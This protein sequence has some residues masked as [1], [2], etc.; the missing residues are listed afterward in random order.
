MTK[1]SSNTS[2][3]S[4]KETSKE[5]RLWL[6]KALKAAR[7]TNRK[8]ATLIHQSC[9]EGEW[10]KQ[11]RNEKLP[12]NKHPNSQRMTETKETKEQLFKRAL[13]VIKDPQSSMTFFVWANGQILPHMD[14]VG[15]HAVIYDKTRQTIKSVDW[16]DED[17]RYC[18]QNNLKRLPFNPESAWWVAGRYFRD[19]FSH[20]PTFQKENLHTMRWKNSEGDYFCGFA[21]PIMMI[22]WFPVYTDHRE[23]WIFTLALYFNEKVKLN[24]DDTALV[25]IFKEIYNG[26]K[27]G[28]WYEFL[29]YCAE[30]FIPDYF[31]FIKAGYETYRKYV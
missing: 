11:A 20:Q 31:R 4:L 13:D 16:Q 15:G 25:Q 8:V 5:T 19:N 21:I 10:Y 3:N 30:Q 17:D 26:H 9:K 12:L 6:S 29:E 24:L 22:P 28:V 14:R 1:N 7:K 2:Q 18:K 23:G 27:Q